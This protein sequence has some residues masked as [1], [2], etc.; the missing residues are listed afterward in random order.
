MFGNLARRH[1]RWPRA[2]QEAE[3]PQ[4]V[5]VCKRC[6]CGDDFC[7]IHSLYISRIVVVIKQNWEPA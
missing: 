6:K 7:F 5:L 4:A 3:N 2:N 1:T